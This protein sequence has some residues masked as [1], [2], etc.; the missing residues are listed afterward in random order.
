MRSLAAY[1]QIVSMGIQ[2]I[3]AYRVQAILETASMLLQVFLRHRQVNGSA[4]RFQ[5]QG[6]E[7][8]RF[9]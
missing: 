6:H 3:A 8:A 4:V 1:L 2:M 9:Q 7:S 5:R